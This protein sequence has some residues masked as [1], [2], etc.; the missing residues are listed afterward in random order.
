M[1]QSAKCL[2]GNV[3]IMPKNINP[4]FTVCHCSMCR[5]WGGGPL[6]M[7]QCGTDVTVEGQEFVTEFDSSRGRSAHFVVAVE[8]TCMQGLS[9]RTV[10]MYR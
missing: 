1:S 7:M 4:E 2:C 10:L 3:T 6:F 8:H 5:K 9:K